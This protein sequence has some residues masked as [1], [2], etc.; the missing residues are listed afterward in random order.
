[1]AF[2]HISVCLRYGV[3]C[4]QLELVVRYSFERV[5]KG[6][7]HS[8]PVG[9]SQNTRIICGWRCATDFQRRGL[10]HGVSC[11]VMRAVI[12]HSEQ[13]FMRSLHAA[14]AT[15]PDQEPTRNVGVAASFDGNVSVSYMCYFAE[16]FMIP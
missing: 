5:L 4:L 15:V 14:G 13:F 12:P 16:P 8:P 2:V 11:A 6:L 1:M 7:L 10:D 3:P 9:D